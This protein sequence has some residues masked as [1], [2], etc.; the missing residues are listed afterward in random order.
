MSKSFFA[1]MEE[2]FSR[3]I[4]LVIAI[5]FFLVYVFAKD[6]QELR[7][8]WSGTL[9]VLLIFWLV[10]EFLS[11]GLY[12]LFVY[13]TKQGRDKTI[14][15]LNSNPEEVESVLDQNGNSEL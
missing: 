14:T 9:F 11:Y 7:I 10:Y 2:V 6:S 3:L 12:V 4:S 5:T 13:F 15:E 8:D 1:G